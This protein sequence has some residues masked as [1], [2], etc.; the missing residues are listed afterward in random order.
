MVL[1][2]ERTGV[3]VASDVE[4]AW[5]SAE[6]RRGLLGRDG[7]ARDAALVITACN[8][9]HSIG[10][11]F[12]IDVAFVDRSGRVRKIVNAM[13]KWRIAGCMSAAL[14]IEFAAGVLDGAIEVGDRVH[15]I[16][17]PGETAVRIPKALVRQETRD[18][19]A[20]MRNRI[21]PELSD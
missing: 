10:M 15:L 6:C 12:E 13:P 4:I 21:V 14:T 1:V 9:V 2:N 20:E 5:T 3:A 11:R 16:A 8:S 18:S 19:G 7:L 17:A